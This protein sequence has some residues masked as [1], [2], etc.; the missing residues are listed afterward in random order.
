[1]NALVTLNFSELFHKPTS[2]FCII[3]Y[4]KSLFFRVF[5][6]DNLMEN[7]FHIIAW[8]FQTGLTVGLKVSFIDI[9]QSFY[10]TCETAK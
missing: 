3:S 2:N 8:Y 7:Q 4:S 6:S 9:W 1:M 5:E 10:G